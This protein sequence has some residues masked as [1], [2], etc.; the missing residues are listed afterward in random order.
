M[1][2]VLAGGLALVAC[3]GE[4]RPSVDVIG[5]SGSASSSSSASSSVSASGTGSSSSSA[6]GT[7]ESPT[8]GVVEDKPA[9][10]EEVDVKLSEFNIEP[11]VTTIDAGKIYFK[12]DNDG[13]EDAHEFV[14]IKTDDKADSLPVTDGRVPEDQVDILGEIEPFTANSSASLTLDLEPGHYV[15]ICNIAEMEDGELE[16][17]YEE[18]MHVDFTVE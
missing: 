16:S 4:D 13:P 8:A 12:V 9:D 1:G 11:S 18:G 7:G 5:D 17:H 15:F 14:V 6:S 2:A 10:A 3:S